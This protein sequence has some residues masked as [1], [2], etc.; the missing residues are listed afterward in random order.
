MQPPDDKTAS[1]KKYIK[2]S[3]QEAAKSRR[4]YSLYGRVYVYIQDFISKGVEMTEVIEAIENSLPPHVVREVDTIFVGNY[5]ELQDRD[6]TAMYDSGAIYVSNEQS[7][8]DDM[9]D[10]IVHEIAHSL[11]GSYGY[12]LYS[13]GSVEKEFLSK[14]LKSYDVLRAWDF[15]PDSSRTAFANVEYNQK[16]DELL[17]KKIGYERLSSLLM[18]IYTTPYAATSLR[19][20]FATGFEDYFLHDAPYLK[21]ISPILFD[22]IDKLVKGEYDG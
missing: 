13:D 12:V 20:Y 4:E 1:V 6:V 7:S 17:Y 10:D 18:G 16:F 3:L 2:A 21:K 14:R 8:V 15:V 5:A 9:V 22:R 11:E 19:E